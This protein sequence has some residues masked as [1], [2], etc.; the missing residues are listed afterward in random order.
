MIKYLGFDKPENVD[1]LS[2]KYDG[3]VKGIDFTIRII[4]EKYKAMKK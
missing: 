4:I 3:K 2:K 1:L